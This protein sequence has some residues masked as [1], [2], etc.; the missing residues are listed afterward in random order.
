MRTKERGKRLGG[1]VRRTLILGNS[2][3]AYSA[4]QCQSRTTFLQRTLL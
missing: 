4:E 1:V 2:N 3:R